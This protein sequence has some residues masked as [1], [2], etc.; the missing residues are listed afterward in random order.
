MQNED[1]SIQQNQ[2]HAVSASLRTQHI[3]EHLEM[4][5]KRSHEPSHDD[6]KRI[7]ESVL[8]IP[9]AYRTIGLTTIAE[10]FVNGM[11]LHLLALVSTFQEKAEQE[12][13]SLKERQTTL[14]DVLPEVKQT[15][16][17]L[18]KKVFVGSL[19]EL[20]ALNNITISLYTLSNAESAQ[21]AQ[22]WLYE[23][24]TTYSRRLRQAGLLLD[25]QN[26]D[27]DTKNQPEASTTHFVNWQPS[28]MSS[29]SQ[30]V[31]QI[32]GTG[33]TVSTPEEPLSKPVPV[34]IETS[35]PNLAA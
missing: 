12:G 21:E 25:E 8:D 14:K 7:I 16:E 35:D 3:L 34:S 22:K 19:D 4:Q 1:R 9:E 20:A 13:I 26:S 23:L 24:P 32:G 15:L 6:F 17:T 31:Q 18:S 10:H 30:V 33:I 27:K 5:L 2:E 11:E 29:K 28:Y